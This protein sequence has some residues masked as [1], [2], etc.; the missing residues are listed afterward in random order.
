MVTKVLLT[1]INYKNMSIRYFLD[2]TSKKDNGFM[3]A[4]CGTSNDG[5]N[6]IITTNGLHSDEVPD[7][8]SEPRTCSQLI[9]GLL[10]AFYNDLNVS[11]MEPSEVIELGLPLEEKNIPHSDNP[12]LPF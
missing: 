6:Y 4:D 2:T 9:A 1:L 8:I 5:E 3:M 10:N 7:E 12:T 11:L